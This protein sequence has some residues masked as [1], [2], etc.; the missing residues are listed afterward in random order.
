MQTCNSDGSFSDDIACPNTCKADKCTSNPGKVF[1]TSTTYKAGDLGGLTGADAKCQA[2]AMA[3]GLTGT[4][5]AWLSDAN[6]QPATRFSKE[7]GP[8]LLVTGSIVANNWTGLTSGTLRHAINVTELGTPAPPATIPGLHE[9]DRVDQHDERRL[10][11]QPWVQLRR[12]DEFVGL[13]RVVRHDRFAVGMDERQLHGRGRH[14]GRDRLWRAGADL[15]RR[16]VTIADTTDAADRS[17]P[18][19][20]TWQSG[21]SAWRARHGRPRASSRASARS[22]PP[23]T[24]RA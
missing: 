19:I 13:L 9:P 11:R 12:L 14:V 5:R 6:G 18:D 7:R 17:A 16:A 3:A 20:G 21:G 8:Y 2:R 10:C 1:V 22:T 15:L 23:P 4:F 24:C